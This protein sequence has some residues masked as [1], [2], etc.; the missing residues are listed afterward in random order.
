MRCPGRRSWRSSRRR[1]WGA[2]RRSCRSTSSSSRGRIRIPPRPLAET[3]EEL[4]RYAF[5]ARV[6]QEIDRLA[7]AGVLTPARIRERIHRLGQT[8]FDEIRLV[9]R[10]DRLLL[11]PHDDR[12][13]YAEFA[14]WYL[15]LRRFAPGLAAEMFPTLGDP[16]AVEAVLAEDLDAARLLEAARPEGATRPEGEA[17]A[18]AAG[19]E[20][21]G[22]GEPAPGPANNVEAAAL[23]TL[24]DEARARGNVVRSA[25]LRVRAGAPD[26][27]RADVEAL[28]G[29][30]DP[31]RCTRGGG[32]RR[33][34]RRGRRR[35]SGWRGTRWR[36]AAS[37][38]AWRRGCSTTC[39]APASRARRPSARSSLVGWALSLGQRPLARLLPATREIRVAH[40]LASA[41][42]KVPRV[43]LPAAARTRLRDLLA[44]ARRRADASLRDELRPV[45]AAALREVGF[46]PSSVPERVAL[47]KIV[48]ELLDQATAH[49]HLGL[50]Q[51]RDAFSRNQ[52][53]MADLAG[54]G[55]L[56]GAD[57]LL[58]ADRRLAADLDGVH[59]RGEIY[60]RTLQKA[61]SLL[62]GTGAGRSLT[63]YVLLPIGGGYML[64]FATGLVVTEIFHL[65][66]IWPHHH[67]LEL[68]PKPWELLAATPRELWLFPVV[69]VLLFGLLH[70]AAVRAAALQAV[71]AVGF[72]L[73]AVFVHAPRW[74]LS[75]PLVQRLLRS[76]AA[77]ALGRFVLKP[78]SIAAVSAGVD[79]LLPNLRWHHHHLRMAADTLPVAIVA[80]VVSAVVLNTRV[81]ILAE[82][83]ALDFLARTLHRVQRDVLPGLY[84]LITRVSRGFTD[85][86]DRGI[87]TVDEWLRFREGQRRPMLALKAV[88]GIGW[89]AIAY[90]LRI[91]VNLLIEPTFNPIKHFPTV[92][93]A[94]KI[95][96]PV[97]RELIHGIS[98]ALRPKVGAF[99]G[100]TVSWL[101]A[102]SLPGF[103]GFLVWELKE[104]YKL[105]Q[106]TRAATLRP[107]PI[108]HHGETMGALLKPG[109]HS[110]TLPKLWAKLRRAARKGDPAVEKHKEAMRE[111]EEAVERFADR[112]LAAML[113]ASERWQGEVRV[114]HVAL[115]SNRVRVE[116]ARGSGAADCVIAFEEQS[117]WLCACV[118]RAGWVAA[119]GD[120]ERVLFENALAGLYQRA[121]V[122]F[123]REQIEAALPPA[124]PYDIADEG[125]VVWPPGWAT[126]LVYDLGGDAD[127]HRRRARRGG[128]A[129]GGAAGHPAGG[130]RVPGA[131]RSPGRTG[132]RR[133]AASRGA[134]CRAR[135][136]CR[137]GAE[138]GHWQGRTTVVGGAIGPSDTCDASK[139]TPIEM[140]SQGLVGSC[141]PSWRMSAAWEICASMESIVGPEQSVGSKL[142]ASWLTAATSEATGITP[143]SVPFV[144]L[145]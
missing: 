41:A 94:A 59:R 70:S 120:E 96:L 115:A 77:L 126:E 21:E 55:E 11:P 114:A 68:V 101:A 4:W 103:F 131:A 91:Y 105:Y 71:R 99:F 67:E 132:W 80:F 136:S 50:G 110:G 93:V 54:P 121:G 90:V 2:P 20:G 61:S 74:L 18:E 133:G 118:A 51:L 6:H 28:A 36:A 88:L 79:V 39:R 44:G 117:G 31:R 138:P 145:W 69:A 140:P 125:L 142:P 57:A 63:F 98:E 83:L 89:F 127:A 102:G 141:V 3:L 12:E 10:Q 19:G 52:L 15:E 48:E 24:A 129:R 43:S 49:G 65:L 30:L 104:N 46:R 112:E 58:A 78:A 34:R 62:F 22:E 116:L 86:I 143:A 60:L 7:A 25:L 134:W 5:H 111:I 72:L 66:G 37:S 73:A 38:A 135:R 1:S 23:R 13:T 17:E 109:L 87:Y 47:A 113:G 95:M 124:T 92:T 100:G 81:G 56:L 123:V 84:R 29:R 137:G 45:T 122:D 42:R 14:A 130:H 106:A 108:G 27:A 85:S 33:R 64:P 16:G 128:R 119:L 76:R 53:K 40:Q 107:V 139:P 35:C 8:E 26:E 9:L 32:R 97:D 144:A 82:E 75:R